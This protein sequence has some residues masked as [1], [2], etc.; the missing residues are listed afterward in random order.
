MTNARGGEC[1]NS[2]IGKQHIVN[3]TEEV[4]F[5]LLRKQDKPFEDANDSGA[6]VHGDSL[7]ALKVILPHYRSRVRVPAVVTARSHREPL[8][9]A[10]KVL[11]NPAALPR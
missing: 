11:A 10:D 4:A 9:L 2:I 5:I 1:R 7:E 8:L 3:P 6:I